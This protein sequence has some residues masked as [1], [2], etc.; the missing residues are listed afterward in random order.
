MSIKVASA[1]W[2][3][4]Q[5]KGTALLMLLAIADYANN[6][7]IAWPSIPSLAAKTRISDRQAKRLVQQLVTAGELAVDVGGGRGHSNL[8]RVILAKGDT[9]DIKG[10]IGD[11][12]YDDVKGDIQ[13]IKGDIQGERVT[14]R[15]IKGDI[16]MSPDPSKNHHKEPSMKPSVEANGI[17]AALAQ[18]QRGIN[19]K[20][21]ISD[22][23]ELLETDVSGMD[24]V[25]CGKWL[26][27]DPWMKGNHVSLTSKMIVTKIDGWIT[28]GR[29]QE[30][31]AASTV[32]KMSKAMQA[33][34]VA[35]EM[36]N[37]EI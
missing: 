5:Q 32:P 36:I 18:L 15:V 6:D 1:I 17:Y 22:I 28:A 8:Y 30:W 34:N 4:S 21:T 11:T 29:P 27:S 3:R 9:G 31:T 10:D 20:Q 2:E 37:E 35:R 13:G 16:A 23:Q 7:G 25:L 12:V 33:A 19:K 26:Q 14:S 24:I